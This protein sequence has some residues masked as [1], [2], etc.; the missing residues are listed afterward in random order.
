MLTLNLLSPKE[1]I[2]SS[3]ML[4]YVIIKNAVL[5][6]LTLSLVVS[7]VLVGAKVILLQELAEVHESTQIVV[8]TNQNTNKKIATFN[9]TLRT[10]LDIQEGFI[11]WS[12]VLRDF[13]TLTSAGITYE[14]INFD[15]VNQK[16]SI[17][18]F[19]R[20]REDLLTL[21]NNLEESDYF[22]NTYIPLNNLL[23]KSDIQFTLTGD[24]NITYELLYD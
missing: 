8:S 15:T 13:N 1:K 4:K 3:L 10:L 24:F 14:N 9:S 16:I 11:P 21:Q 2:A 23:Q 18:G 17:T 7:G 22:S 5:I 12:K 19:A 6:I 20:N